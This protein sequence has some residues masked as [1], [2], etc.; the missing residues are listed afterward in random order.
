MPIKSIGGNATTYGAPNTS[1]TSQSSSSL[2]KGIQ[3]VGHSPS[4]PNLGH[5]RRHS[6]DLR[7]V[8]DNMADKLRGV[9]TIKREFFKP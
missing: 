4:K 8:G 5:A 1:S 9:V 6:V 7:N 3:N 2:G